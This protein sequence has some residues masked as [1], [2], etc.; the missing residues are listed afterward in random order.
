MSNFNF[1]CMIASTV[2]SISSSQGDGIGWLVWAG[3]FMVMGF[4][5][6]ALLAKKK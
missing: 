3:M 4:T 6:Y 5:P 2:C 1:Y